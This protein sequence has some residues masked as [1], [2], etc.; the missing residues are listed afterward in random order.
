VAY[1]VFALVVTMA[2]RS[3]GLGE[4]LPSWMLQLFDP[5]DK[6]NLAPYRIL[7][8]LALVVA[9]TRF[10][11]SD[12]PILRWRSL[13]PLITC[14]QN[15]LLVFCIGVVLS[16]C[17][18]AAIELS[19]NSV[20]VQISVGCTGIVFMTAGAYYWTWSK[21]RAHTSVAG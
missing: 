3:P 14:G 2:L 11:P 13:A 4:L 21:R 7:H 1:V 19:L 18:D 15:S 20:W 8:L 16:F 10:L 6:T 17:A 9:V 5:N 12:S